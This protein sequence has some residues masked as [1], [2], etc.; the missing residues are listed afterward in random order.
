MLC[1]QDGL[2][3][4]PQITASTLASSADIVVSYIVVTDVALAASA[5]S[6]LLT[7]R[8]ST[9]LKKGHLNYTSTFIFST[10]APNARSA[11]AIAS[12]SAH[13]SSPIYSFYYILLYL[14]KL[15]SYVQTSP[16]IHFSIYLAP[17]IH[18]NLI[19]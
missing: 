9:I 10:D 14:S 1:W 16:I 15:S 11:I 18:Y 4:R 7:P 2:R 17:T 5:V 3:R 8:T 12:H 6:A 13:I 19:I